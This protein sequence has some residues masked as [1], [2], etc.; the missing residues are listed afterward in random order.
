MT[1][2]EE[3]QIDLEVYYEHL[4]YKH[5]PP[6]VM[7]PK[8][9][10]CNLL[11]S[12]LASKSTHSLLSRFSIDS[13][14]AMKQKDEALKHDATI[15]VFDAEMQS[16]LIT[17]PKEK[18]FYSISLP[19]GL[20]PIRAINEEFIRDKVVEREKEEKCRKEKVE[21]ENTE[22]VPDNRLQSSTG[23]YLPFIIPLG[24]CIRTPPFKRPPKS[25]TKHKEHECPLNC[26]ENEDA[27]LKKLVCSTENLL[28]EMMLECKARTCEEV[29]HYQVIDCIVLKGSL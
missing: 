18:Y 14:L 22:M 3:P 26:K 7:P 8:F 17:L 23:I 9:N 5:P 2:E 20:T 19:S 28:L 11:D 29:S 10:V 1:V 21:K 27:I 15:S 4:K 6:F 24:P 25:C 12:K 13:K 16:K